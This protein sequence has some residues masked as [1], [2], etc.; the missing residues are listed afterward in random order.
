M[1][2]SKFENYLKKY[3]NLKDYI[4]ILRGWETVSLS[5]LSNGITVELVE[6]LRDLFSKDSF[7]SIIKC[8]KCGL[9][10]YTLVEYEKQPSEERGMGVEYQHIFYQNLNCPYCKNE[11]NI[12]YIIW[13]YPECSINHT[14]SNIKGCEIE[15]NNFKRATCKSFRED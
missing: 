8:D 4:K 1:E 6:K 2:K 13:E 3:N 11:I 10:F 12:E 9:K 15:D 14:E 7:Y 5:S